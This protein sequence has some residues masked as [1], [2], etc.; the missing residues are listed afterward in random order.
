MST[1]EDENKIVEPENAYNVIEKAYSE[2]L[3]NRGVSAAYGT[4]VSVGNVTVIPTAETL[5]VIGIGVGS[6]YGSGQAPSQSAGEQQAGKGG[7]GGGGGG[8]RTFSR[9]VAVV[10]IDQQSVRVEPVVDITQIGLA[11]LTAFGI[12]FAFGLGL[13]KSS[14]VLRRLK[15]NK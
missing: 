7:A 14:D 1:S 3:S 15:G 10:V 5:S 13:V 9:P 12:M 6:M 4:P 11:A 2:L 8:G